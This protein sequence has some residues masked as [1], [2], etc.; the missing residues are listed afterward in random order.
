MISRIKD[1]G[2]KIKD[3]RRNPSFLTSLRLCH[4]V[5]EVGRLALAQAKQSLERRSERG[6][7]LDSRRRFY[8]SRNLLPVLTNEIAS[9]LAMTPFFCH[10]EPQAKQSPVDYGKRPSFLKFHESFQSVNLLVLNTSEIAS[11]LAMTRLDNFQPATCN[12]QPLSP[13]IFDFR[14]ST[15]DLLS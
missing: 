1:Q 2:S 15:F 5:H 13:S 9:C 4:C 11:Y 6:F 3:R 7:A 8:W 14:F 10:C 12:L